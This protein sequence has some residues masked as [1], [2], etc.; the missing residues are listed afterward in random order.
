MLAC[1]QS[2][3][4]IIGKIAHWIKA[5]INP[6]PH[7]HRSAKVAVP[8]PEEVIISGV[9]IFIKTLTGRTE[10][11]EIELTDLVEDLKFRID[12]K[13]KIPSHSQRLI[14]QQKQLED[15]KTLESYN[16]R[17]DST[18]HLA[19]RLV[20]GVS[21]S[22]Q[23]KS[24]TF[25]LHTEQPHPTPYRQD[26]S[27]IPLIALPTSSQP[28]VITT[29]PISHTHVQSDLALPKKNKRGS[30]TKK[31][32]A[33]C[34]NAH[35]ACDNGRPCKRCLQLGLTDCNDAQRR[36]GTKRTFGEFDETKTYAP[37]YDL[38]PL[39]ENLEAKQPK[40]EEIEM[41]DEAIDE[42]FS[43]LIDS[44]YEFKKEVPQ[45][46]KEAVE[47]QEEEQDATLD[48][49]F[50]KI[51]DL[52]PTQDLLQLGPESPQDESSDQIVKNILFTHL[53][54]DA[55]LVGLKSIVT[56]LSN[57]LFGGSIVK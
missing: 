18:I 56:G 7:C 14:F 1:A 44:D 39:L 30:Y 6:H 16:I 49:A 35:H 23:T 3:H 46:K 25:N 28:Q 17:K 38:A 53:Q 42:L 45:V 37:M 32:C 26:L 48:L 36:K 57:Y 52:L 15:G 29:F 24:N 12:T 4:C 47:E 8:Q 2:N 33:N 21:V 10:I 34:R 43:N 40:I 9:P 31:A 54:Q 13:L 27:Q 19:L 11:I 51:V 20:A 55:N 22:V 41:S 50:D 5:H